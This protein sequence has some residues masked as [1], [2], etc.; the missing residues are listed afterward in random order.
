[1]PVSFEDPVPELTAD[2]ENAPEE[3]RVDELAQLPNAGEKQLVLHHAVLHPGL[4]GELRKLERFA[5]C[6]G[7]WF[8]AVHVLAARDGSPNVRRTEVG[9][10]RV[11]VNRR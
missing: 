7:E 9:E 2:A 3:S 11:E 10:S 4:G 6:G 8:L 1:S 5:G